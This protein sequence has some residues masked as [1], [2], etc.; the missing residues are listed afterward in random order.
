M[1]SRRAGVAES[2]KDSQT[3]S[4]RTTS[5]PKPS[6]NRT[7][8]PWAVPPIPTNAEVKKAGRPTEPVLS[9]V[10][11]LMSSHLYQTY[12]NIGL[13]ADGVAKD[14]YKVEDGKDL[15]DALTRITDTIERQIA[16]LPEG[17]LQAEER[18]Q[19]EKTRRMLSLLR[20]Q[21]K[22]L[23][24]YWDSGDEDYLKPLPEDPR[25]TSRRSWTCS[26][27]MAIEDRSGQRGKGASPT[28][29][30]GRRG[31]SCLAS[32]FT[33]PCAATPCPRAPS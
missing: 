26:I 12:L 2:A 30:F 15:L 7:P 31:S 24:A 1:V 6:S 27:A 18:A 9:L 28:S 23:K 32:N 11:G 10:G 14:V 17:E 19:L 13:I 4:D 5:D 20:S 8:P 25:R 29:F 16:Q 21:A 22:E 3:A 33:S